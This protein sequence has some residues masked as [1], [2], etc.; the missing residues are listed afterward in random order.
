MKITKSRAI[1]RP[2]CFSSC[3][4]APVLPDSKTKISAAH[5]RGNVRFYGSRLASCVSRCNSVPKPCISKPKHGAR[6]WKSAVYRPRFS[7]SRTTFRTKCLG[8]ALM[9]FRSS[10][11]SRTRNAPSQR[12]HVRLNYNPRVRRVRNNRRRFIA[13]VRVT[14][15]TAGCVPQERNKSRVQQSFVNRKSHEFYIRKHLC[16]SQ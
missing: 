7:P 4:L 14:Q 8:I 6:T 10:F 15:C 13:A 2:S 9:A 12:S 11:E 1:D 16:Y 5:L 3:L